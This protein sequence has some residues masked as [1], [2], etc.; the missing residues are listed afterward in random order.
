[1][2][3]EVLVGTLL[4]PIPFTGYAFFQAMVAA[5][6]IPTPSGPQWPKW[7]CIVTFTLAV[8]LSLFAGFLGCALVA[9]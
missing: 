3:L 7:V 4:I 6:S 1:M 9:A 8:Y 2:S 5:E